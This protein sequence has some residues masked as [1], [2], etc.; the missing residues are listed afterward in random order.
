M[1]SRFLV[2]VVPC[3][4]DKVSLCRKLW[5]AVICPEKTAID[6]GCKE[7][8]LLRNV[9][10]IPCLGATRGFINLE[11]LVYRDLLDLRVG[12]VRARALFTRLDGGRTRQSLLLRNRGVPPFL[13]MIVVKVRER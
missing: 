5:E 1:H 11:S 9:I 13:I 3:H 2:G 12:I 4:F 7:N 10:V 8:N 6:G